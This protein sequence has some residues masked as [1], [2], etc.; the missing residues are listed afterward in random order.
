MF[1]IVT[2]GHGWLEVDGQAPCLLQPGSLTL[3]P[4]GAGHRICSELGTP[5]QK[6][7]NLPVD[8]VS[9]RYEVLRYGGGGVVTHAMC[10]VVRF[11]HLL[12]QRLMTHLPKILQVNTWSEDEASWLQSTLRFI[13]KEAGASRPGGETVITHL[14]DILV[15]QALRVWLDT[16]P[17]AQ[18]GWLA[19]LR[20]PHIGKALALMHRAP[21]QDWTVEALAD[22]VAMS[23]SAFSARFTS[24]VGE[25][26]MQ[27]LTLWRMQLARAH[28]Q[29]STEPLGRVAE[30]VGYQSE[31][32]FS[33]AFKRAFGTSP[34]GTRHAVEPRSA[35]AAGDKRIGQ[36]LA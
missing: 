17:E 5:A 9:E 20:D 6:F 35:S 19:A 32:A 4:H 15:I 29:Q 23:R 25:S 26:A 28:L 21:E 27:H 18:Q 24:L 13:G 36:S 3:I 16:A 2:V 34:R 7:F 14:A 8:Q 30:R 11:D 22:R 10:G 12:A 1:H 33:R 31:A